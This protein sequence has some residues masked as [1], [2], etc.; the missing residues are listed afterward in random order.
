M[1]VPSLSS[2]H[3]CFPLAPALSAFPPANFHC[4][5]RRTR[6]PAAAERS[7]KPQPG[8]KAPSVPPHLEDAPPFSYVVPTVWNENQQNAM[9]Y[10][11]SSPGAAAQDGVTAA[12]VAAALGRTERSIELR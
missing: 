12:D 11:H 4:R 5:P 2:A 10:L 8:G 6:H 1:T 3:L 7:V 9:L